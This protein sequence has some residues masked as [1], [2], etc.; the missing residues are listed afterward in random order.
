MD[1]AGTGRRTAALWAV[2][3]ASRA[4]LLLCALRVLVFP[5]PDVTSDVSVIYRGWYEVLRQGAFPV[6]DVAWQYPPGAA[7]AIL[8][9]AAL[10]FLGYATAFFVLAL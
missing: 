6:G 3:G 4:V 1:E 5:G 9:P 2:W 10:P 7:L 8:A